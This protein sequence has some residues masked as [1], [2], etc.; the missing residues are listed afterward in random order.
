[1]AETLKIV[2]TSLMGLT[3]GCA[4]CHDHRYDPIPQRDYYQLRAIFEPGLDPK[5]WRVPNSRRITLFTDA[6]RKTSAAIEVEAKK[7]DGVRQKKVD[8][9]IDRTLTWKLEAVPEEAR[10]P[11]REA[12]RSKKRNDEQNALLKKYPS[13]RQISAGSLYLYDREYSGEISKLNTERKK[14]ADKKDDPKAAAELK[15]IDARIKFFRDALSKKVLDA[16]AKKAAD[17]RATKP[18]EPFIR[19]LTE[20]A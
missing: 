7:L 17:L 8:F 12:Y 2:S 20:S 9:F 4:Q 13:V 18:E 5:S 3:V 14:F 11:L 16:M 19:A 15:N 6:D 1:M 10:K